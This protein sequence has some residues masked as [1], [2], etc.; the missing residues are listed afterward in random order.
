MSNKAQ[1]QSNQKAELLSTAL[2]GEASEFELRQLLKSATDD[3]AVRQQWAMQQLTR[4]AI[5]GEGVDVAM[6]D[7]SFADR[8]GSA[9]ADEYQAESTGKASWR[10]PAA[11]FAVAA[12]VMAAVLTTTYMVNQ[13]QSPEIDAVALSQPVTQS[14]QYLA[15]QSTTTPVFGGG[16]KASAGQVSPQAYINTSVR[17]SSAAADAVARQRLYWY[18]NSHA[19]HSA[20]NSGQGMMQFARMVDQHE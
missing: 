15:S 10:L 8:V 11:K 6:L 13:Q 20:L 7:L 1:T 9:V 16:L 17:S 3:N 5:K 14:T 12:S 18:M 4:S 19:E 2:D